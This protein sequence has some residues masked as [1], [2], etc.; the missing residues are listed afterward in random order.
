MGFD[1]KV[2]TTK[3]WIELLALFLSIV[4]L[5]AA[6]YNIPFSKLLEKNHKEDFS[7]LRTLPY[8]NVNYQVYPSKIQEKYSFG[9]LFDI[10]KRKELVVYALKRDYNQ[11]FQ[12]KVD[13]G[14]IGEDVRLAS[15]LGKFL[16][17]K[18]TYKMIYNS[19]DDVVD[20]VN[21]GEG[22]I[23]LAKLSYTPERSRKVL[24]SAPYVNSRKMV[25]IDRIA[26]ADS[27]N[28][29]L[30]KVLNNKKSIIGVIKGTSYESFART[31]FP[32]A[33][34]SAEE[35]WEEGAVAKLEKGELVAVLRDELRI[36]TLMTTNPKLL[37]NFMPVILKGEEDSMAAIT[38]LNGYA[39]IMFI[40]KFI[41]NEYKAT[42]VNEIIDYYRGM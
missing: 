9:N 4:G 41:E 36:K 26:A 23:G 1:E 24:Y 29:T 2:M 20:A 3:K 25:L 19:N 16:G 22:D 35:K 18:V 32:K 39:L 30:L 42:S 37:L 40:N 14:Y 38:N 12:M 31:L 6:C 17:V 33:Q 7:Y 10:L 8:K 5:G 15:E 27:V 11:F 13:G 34:I 21:R 28:N